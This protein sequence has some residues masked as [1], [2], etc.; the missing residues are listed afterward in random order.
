[1]D[2]QRDDQSFV[3]RV[4]WGLEPSLKEKTNELGIDFDRFIE[5]LKN[6]KSDSEMAE[7][8]NVSREAILSL[9]EHFEHLG[10][11]SIVGLD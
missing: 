8:F 10:I 7:E 4:P 11:Q 3:S 6:N 9:R 2:D 1:M 5:G